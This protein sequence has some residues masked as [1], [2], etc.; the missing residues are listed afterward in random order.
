MRI[1]EI[2]SLQECT[3]PAGYGGT[4]RFVHFLSEELVKKGCDVTVVCKKGSLGGSYKSV[5]VV[6]DALATIEKC[7]EVSK[8]ELIH[9]NTKI[10]GL[11]ELLKKTNVPVV[12]TFH[13]NFRKN[14][15]WV[16]TMKDPL[17]NFYFTTISN[18]LKSRV[19]EAL[20]FNNVLM[21]KHGITNLGFGMDVKNYQ[22]KYKSETK[23]YYIY[24]GVIARYKGVLDLVKAFQKSDEELLLVGPAHTVEEQNYLNEIINVTKTFPNISYYGETKNEEE[25]INLLLH[26]KGLLVASG[27]DPAESDCHE[28]FGLV[29][30]EANSVGVPVIGYSKGNVTDYIQEGING[31]K[32]SDTDEM[33]SHIKKLE[34]NNLTNSCMKYALKFDI[35]N[36]VDNYLKY[37]TNIGKN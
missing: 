21:P 3:P 20:D 24:I 31:Y 32:F 15:S 6:S 13:N 22:T 28:A 35:S 18:N 36:I 1:L 37:F 2:S 5:E 9:V 14:S 7:I 26:A 17:Y 11:T 33:P 23:G 19:E 12:F 30:L 29:M 27:Y 34:E 4:E 8:P 10:A 16:E 25:K